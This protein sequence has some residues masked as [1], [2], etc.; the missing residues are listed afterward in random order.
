MHVSLHDISVLNNSLR[1]AK[2]SVERDASH[3]P[4]RDYCGLQSWDEI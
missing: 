2:M 1:H 3:T 4:F